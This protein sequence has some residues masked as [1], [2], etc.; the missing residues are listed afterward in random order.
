MELVYGVRREEDVDAI[1]SLA[2]ELFRAPHA[3]TDAGYLRETILD[4]AKTPRG[5]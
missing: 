4:W 2:F 1:A 5:C 3:A